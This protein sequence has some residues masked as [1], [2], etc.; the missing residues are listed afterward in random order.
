[1]IFSIIIFLG[2]VIYWFNNKDT[3]EENSII[4]SK[5]KNST[6]DALVKENVDENNQNIDSSVS[7]ENQPIS[8]IKNNDQNSL[9]DSS[10]DIPKKPSNSS[11]SSPEIN[12]LQVTIEDKVNLVISGKF[13]NGL[14]RKNALGSEYDIIQAKVNEL[15]RSRN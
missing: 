9:V 10:N 5:D 8:T 6:D 14:D 2:V 1:M 11:T 7:S 3:K 13:G 15:Y 4:T 12:Q